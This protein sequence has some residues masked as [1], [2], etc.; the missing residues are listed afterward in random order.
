MLLGSWSRI[1]LL[2]RSSNLIV[3]LVLEGG[4]FILWSG[5]FFC[6]GLCLF[7]LGIYEELKA[8]IS[9]KDYSVVFNNLFS[10]FLV[11]TSSQANSSE[12]YF[13]LATCSLLQVNMYSY[14]H[15]FLEL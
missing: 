9:E 13:I 3:I 7:A 14:N 2:F 11:I 10:C 8:I 4:C 15:S 5:P 1:N 6:G 12:S